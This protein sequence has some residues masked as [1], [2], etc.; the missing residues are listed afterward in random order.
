MKEYLSPTLLRR[1]QSGKGRV[2]TDMSPFTLRR[3][4]GSERRNFCLESGPESGVETAGSCHHCSAGN[5]FVKKRLGVGPPKASAGKMG[6][7]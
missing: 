2:G 6:F 3:C 5:G 7:H 1:S 4:G